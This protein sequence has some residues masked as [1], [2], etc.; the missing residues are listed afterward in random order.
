MVK[1]IGG[2]KET[3][4]WY[5]A[6][7]QQMLGE[8]E[9][10][11]NPGRTPHMLDD[12]PSDMT[13]DDFKAL[14]RDQLCDNLMRRVESG[15]SNQYSM[16]PNGVSLSVGRDGLDGEA[17]W[18]CKISE[19]QSCKKAL[20]DMA[21]GD[22]GRR[23]DGGK[24]MAAQITKDT[25]CGN[26]TI[27]FPGC[28]HCKEP[29]VEAKPPTSEDNPNKAPVIIEGNSQCGNDPGA[30]SSL[31]AMEMIIK[32]LQDK[33]GACELDSS[34]GKNG[35][36]ECTELGYKTY[37]GEVLLGY[38]NFGN[39]RLR[40]CA[41]AG[42]KGHRELL[43]VAVYCLRSLDF[44]TTT[45]TRLADMQCSSLAAEAQQFVKDCSGSAVEIFSIKHIGG[46][47]YVNGDG[48]YLLTTL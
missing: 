12:R 2:D 36:D 42:N 1:H 44:L 33:G 48:F 46:R 37:P 15:D 13:G 4:Q 29:E 7:L 25:G 8:S 38:G 18:G 21:N 20:E 34:A 22:S 27:N 43:P 10:N 40:F 19:A 26:I 35:D 30:L 6:M 23:G 17:K 24:W 41:P 31:N 11:N 39:A 9:S 14:A 5:S 3:L 32:D 28:S 45:D 47:K 16:Y